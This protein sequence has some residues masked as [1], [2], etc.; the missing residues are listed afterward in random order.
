MTMP[1]FGADASDYRASGSYAG[2]IAISKEIDGAVMPQLPIGGGGAVGTS[3][4]ETYQNCYVN[5]SVKY[6]ESPNNLNSEYR[7]ACF[8]SCDA[9]YRLCGPSVGIGKRSPIFGGV[10]SVTK[11]G[12]ANR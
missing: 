4:V 8:D 3:C 1:G 11:T 9:S 7:Q 6:P 10:G 5:C 2:S 12:M